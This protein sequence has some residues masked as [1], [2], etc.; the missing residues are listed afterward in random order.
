MP[1]IYT[2]IECV[3]SDHNNT[4]SVN[5]DLRG[6]DKIVTHQVRKTRKQGT[7]LYTRSTTGKPGSYLGRSKDDTFYE[8]K[9]RQDA[10]NI[11]R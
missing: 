1:K 8:H 10:K 5:E 4:K 2:P 11:K 3:L 9:L 6:N 7:F